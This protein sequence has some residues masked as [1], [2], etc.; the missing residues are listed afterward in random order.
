[1]YSPKQKNAILNIMNFKKMNK[2]ITKK[3]IVNPTIDDLKMVRVSVIFPVKKTSTYEDVLMEMEEMTFTFPDDGNVEI[4]ETS[5]NLQD[6]N[7]WINKTNMSA[8]DHEFY[9]GDDY[10]GLDKIIK[11]SKVKKKK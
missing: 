5:I 8:N 10:I 7:S 6:I 1:M 9:F 11:N 3:E 2:E 4:E